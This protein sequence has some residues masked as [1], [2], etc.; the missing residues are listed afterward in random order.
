MFGFKKNAK[1]EKLEKKVKELEEAI[2][3]EKWRANKFRDEAYVATGQ[4]H[5][6]RKSLAVA[7]MKIMDQ[8]HRWNDLV[9]L[10]NSKGGQQF[11]DGPSAAESQFS[12]KDLKILIGLCHPDK[13]GGKESAHKMTQKL[14]EMRR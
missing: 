5:E 7:N 8:M 4:L 13:H 10:I 2:V 1:I 11:L 12:E 14:L 3:Y 9:E 6:V